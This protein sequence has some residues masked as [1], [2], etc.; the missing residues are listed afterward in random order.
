MQLFA[1]HSS[2]NRTT[3]PWAVGEPGQWRTSSSFPLNPSTLR[4]EPLASPCQWCPPSRHPGT[5]Q[6]S[7]LEWVK[8]ASHYH[9]E[10]KTT[11]K[12]VGSSRDSP[13]L[14]YLKNWHWD[15]LSNVAVLIE[16]VEAA[17][18][19]EGSCKCKA[20]FYQSPT[21]LLTH[22]LRENWVQT[23]Y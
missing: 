17:V 12:K 21:E 1:L 6:E 19:P 10:R 18:H 11:P 22:S 4:C 23:F 3:S 9:S 2:D 20:D 15:F 14:S 8:S 5:G 13:E 16:V 7:L